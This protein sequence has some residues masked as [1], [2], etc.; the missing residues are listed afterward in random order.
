MN[1]LFLWSCISWTPQFL[2]FLRNSVT[3]SAQWE[4]RARHPL[5]GLGG[6]HPVTLCSLQRAEAMH[7]KAA[8]VWS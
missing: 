6:E 7:H 8:Q 2:F 3:S 4:G 5:Q 1:D